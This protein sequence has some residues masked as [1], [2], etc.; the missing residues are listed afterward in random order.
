M[1]GVA[2]W[3]IVRVVLCC[4]TANFNRAVHI[5]NT[6]DCMNCVRANNKSEVN[7]K[8]NQEHMH[9]SRYKVIYKLFLLN[10]TTQLHRL[11]RLIHL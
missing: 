1:S 2:L 6:F 10:P 5:Y 9:I 4:P 11:H 3:C 7:R 8:V